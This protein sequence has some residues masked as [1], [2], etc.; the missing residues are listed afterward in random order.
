MEFSFVLE[1]VVVAAGVSSTWGGVTS[2]EVAVEGCGVEGSFELGN[3][4]GN[5]PKA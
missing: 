2:V 5:S 4:S 1:F 3:N